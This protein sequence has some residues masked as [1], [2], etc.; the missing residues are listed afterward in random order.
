VADLPAAHTGLVARG[1]DFVQPPHR[2]ARLPDHD[3]WM[4]FLRDSEGNLL[5]LMSEVPPP[6]AS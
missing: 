1:A 4:A 5:G 3:L 2:I 6:A